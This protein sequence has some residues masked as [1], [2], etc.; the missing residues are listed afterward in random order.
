MEKE[1]VVRWTERG[2]KE[3]EGPP[4]SV[5]FGT[6]L[7]S[8][9]VQDSFGGSVFYDWKPDGWKSPCFCRWNRSRAK[10]PPAKINLRDAATAGNGPKSR[11]VHLV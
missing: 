10:R 2:S 8:R 4:A 11:P 3:I 5:G 1:I 6:Q 9:T 7:V